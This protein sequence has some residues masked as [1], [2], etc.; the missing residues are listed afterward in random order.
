[1]AFAKKHMT[2]ADPAVGLTFNR[3]TFA[4]MWREWSTENIHRTAFKGCV[5]PN[6][7]VYDMGTNK[8]RKHLDF[9]K[10]GRTLILKAVSDTC[11][12]RMWMSSKLFVET[13]MFILKMGFYYRFQAY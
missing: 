9:Q 7:D 4:Y 3:H 11:L 6:N 1:M 13:S 5:A 12:W 2:K 8:E 10:E